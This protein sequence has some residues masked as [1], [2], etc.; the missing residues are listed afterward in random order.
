MAF[1]CGSQTLNSTRLDLS[2]SN[3]LEK[4]SA[5]RDFEKQQAANAEKIQAL[6]K[7]LAEAR[8]EAVVA[9]KAREELQNSLTKIKSQL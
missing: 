7:L 8:S 3:D 4:V 1:R 6:T 2:S 9:Q 5:M